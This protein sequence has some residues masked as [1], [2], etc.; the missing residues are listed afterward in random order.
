M[1]SE[2]ARMKV[3]AIDCGTNSIR[4]LIAELSPEAGGVHMRDVRREMRIVRLGQDVDRTK[5]FH[6][7]ALAR[8]F[9]A[10]KEYA[11]LIRAEG[12]QRIRFG[13]TSAT[14]DATNREEFIAGIRR[15]LGVTPEVITGEEE[16][17]LSFIG[18]SR[19]ISDGAA[20]V[21]VVDLGGGSTE[22]VLGRG[23]TTR[24]AV[25]IDV[26]S[27]R[28]TE[29]YLAADPPS[30]AEIANARADVRAAIAEVA[31]AVPLAEVD[32]LVGTAG[33]ITTVTA[34]ALGLNSYEPNRI[35]GAKLPVSAI[36]SACNDLLTRTRARR[37][38][39]GF[40]HPGRVDVIGGGALIWQE[41]THMV[42]EAAT[43]AGRSLGA[44]VTS[45]HDILDGLALSLFIGD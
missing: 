41:V 35:N 21:L 12:V 29:R 15:L 10:A 8:T 17:R 27:V 16:A 3:A 11:G 31:G 5:Q 1:T 9:E 44:V 4:L 14:R 7:D 24:A 6:P 19:V 32:T 39:L 28:I 13:A 30:D 42:A 22:F 33:T 20:N 36:D 37:A 38:A 45:E 34:H 40:M 26:G 25:S 43:S 18:A 23:D 2:G